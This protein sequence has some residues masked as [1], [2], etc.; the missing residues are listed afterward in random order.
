ML[1]LRTADG[2]FVKDA[3]IARLRRDEADAWIA[4]RRDGSEV[5]LARFF[6][7][8]GRVEEHLPHLLPCPEAVL[9]SRNAD[10]PCCGLPAC[11]AA[12]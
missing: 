7:A 6:S 8:P 3:S 12:P 1:Y 4:T 10:A 2:G 11:Q 5:A 9:P